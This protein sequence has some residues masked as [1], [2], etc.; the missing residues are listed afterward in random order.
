MAEPKKFVTVVVEKVGMYAQFVVAHI[1]LIN[2]MNIINSKV[3]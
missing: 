2:I 3:T 1:S